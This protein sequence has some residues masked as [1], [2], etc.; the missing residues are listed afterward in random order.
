MK[1]VS[2]AYVEPE[3]APTQRKK[4]KNKF[5]CNDTSTSFIRLATANYEIPLQAKD[6]VLLDNHYRFILFTSSLWQ[7]SSPRYRDRL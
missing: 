3:E 2:S 4:E 7:L 6:K 5:K 1:L